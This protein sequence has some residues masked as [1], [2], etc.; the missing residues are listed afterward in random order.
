M[1]KTDASAAEG[2]RTWPDRMTAWQID[3]Y[4]AFEDSAVIND[5]AELPA[6]LGPKEVLVRVKASSVNPIDV[7]MAGK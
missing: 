1:T 7:L 3:T 2:G 6:S 4:A 5:K